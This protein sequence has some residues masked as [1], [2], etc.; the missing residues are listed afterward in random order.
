M[1]IYMVMVLMYII[2]IE[3]KPTNMTNQ[4]FTA[5]TLPTAKVTTKKP[6]WNPNMTTKL[7]LTLL[8]IL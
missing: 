3:R 2:Y 4:I 1:A 7:A 6:A 8:F 5:P